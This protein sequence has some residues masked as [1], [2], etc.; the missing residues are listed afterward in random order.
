MVKNVNHINYYK[1]EQDV[2]EV[3]VETIKDTIEEV[4]AVKPVP[5]KTLKTQELIV[6]LQIDKEDVLFSLKKSEQLEILKKLG[7]SDKE[8]KKLKLEK[9]R[10]DK[11]LEFVRK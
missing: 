2:K 7:L 4:P 3:V 5:V 1:T 8:I 9:Q 11:I 6:E 10:V